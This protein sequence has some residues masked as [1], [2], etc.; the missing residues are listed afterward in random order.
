MS[1][2]DHRREQIAL[3][4]KQRLRRVSLF[5]YLLNIRSSPEMIWVKLAGLQATTNEATCRKQN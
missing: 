1:L 4:A 5:Y 3:T 2:Y